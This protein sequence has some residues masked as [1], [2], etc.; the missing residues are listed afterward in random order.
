M[1]CV[2]LSKLSGKDYYYENYDYYYENYGQRKFA[3][4][5]ML[6]KG[7]KGCLEVIYKT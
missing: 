5:I 7:I 6:V 4:V 3:V 2:V 1:I